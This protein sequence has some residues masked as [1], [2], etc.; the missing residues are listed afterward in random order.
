LYF[1]NFPSNQLRYKQLTESLTEDTTES[2]YNFDHQSNQLL[3][4]PMLATVYCVSRSLPQQR[5]WNKISALCKSCVATGQTGPH[6]DADRR[7]Q[8]KAYSL[9]DG[10]RYYHGY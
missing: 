2:V 4:L 6:T 3:M 10:Y 5:A 1:L 7:L 8:T 9:A